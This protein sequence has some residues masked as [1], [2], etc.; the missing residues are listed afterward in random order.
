MY[1]TTNEQRKNLAYFP[2]R[3]KT[4]FI[5]LKVNIQIYSLYNFCLHK[6]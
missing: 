2:R 5:V 3:E 4:F 1:Y 6:E